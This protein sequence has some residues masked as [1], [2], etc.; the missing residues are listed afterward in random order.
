MKRFSVEIDKLVVEGASIAPLHGEQFRLLVEQA[1][2]QRLKNHAVPSPVAAR[3]SVSVSV[4]PVGAHEHAGGVQL[5]RHV[6]QAIHHSL[7]R[8]A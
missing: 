4:P 6:A 8:K 5:A 7:T 3:E 1:L 2:Q